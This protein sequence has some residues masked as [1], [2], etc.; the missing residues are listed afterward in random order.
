[1]QLTKDLPLK[2]FE[3]FIIEKNQAAKEV[4]NK[5][6]HLLQ[7]QEKIFNSL[8]LDIKKGGKGRM[9]INLTGEIRIQNDEVNNLS[10]AISNITLT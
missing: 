7:N 8:S 4:E 2:C 3:D 5:F 6:I 1:M 10:V 9:G